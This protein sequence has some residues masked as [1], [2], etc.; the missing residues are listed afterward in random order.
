VADINQKIQKIVAAFRVKYKLP[1][2]QYIFHIV[3]L[4]VRHFKL[5][6]D[7]CYGMVSTCVQYTGSPD[8]KLLQK[9]DLF[10]T[11]CYIYLAA[12]QREAFVLST[13]KHELTHIAIEYA[14]ENIC[15]ELATSK[16]WGK[17]K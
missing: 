15:D 3:P 1:S 17:K 9:K 12:K 11:H 10:V 13:V 4:N 2:T 14:E 6:D 8:N 5:D 7:I 16:S